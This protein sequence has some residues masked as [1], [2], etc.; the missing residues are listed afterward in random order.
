MGTSTGS[1]GEHV[2][3][4]LDKH[5]SIWIFGDYGSGSALGTALRAS[6]RLL[7]F[8]GARLWLSRHSQFWPYS[9]IN[10]RIFL[11][12]QITSPKLYLLNTTSSTIIC[13]CCGSSACSAF[14]CTYVR[15]SC[16]STYRD[17]RNGTKF[18][19]LALQTMADYALTQKVRSVVI[20][21]DFH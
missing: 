9:A 13:N 21:S 3:D 2:S 15:Y 20:K 6:A 4:C 7:F 19:V 10:S 11:K 12:P 1:L 17:D 14:A 5:G 18:A 8:R 16:Y